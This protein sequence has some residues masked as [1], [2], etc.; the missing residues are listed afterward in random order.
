MT[1]ALLLETA[2]RAFAA[3]CTPAALRRAE[4]EGWA[5]DVWKAAAGIGL[6]WVGV[7]E[8]AG[9]AG[10]DLVDAVE[11]LRVAGAHAAPV[12][13]AE[14]GFLAGWLLAS[15][16]LPVG[17]EPL[18]VVPDGRGL[19]L[20]P[21]G[22]GGR[23][24]VSGRATG[25]A[26]AGRARAVVALV[27]ERVVVVPAASLH[28]EPSTNLAGEPRA[29]V[30]F[31]GAVPEADAAAPPGVTADA[32]RHRGALSRA[33]LMAGALEAVAL[34]TAAYTWERHQFG[35]PIATFQ[36]V[37]SMVVRA[38][39]EAV[40]ADLAVQAAARAALDGPATFEIGAAKLLAN[41][42][43]RTVTRAAH[44]AHG[45]I[46][47]TEEQ[48]LHHLTRRLWAWR[49]EYG[50]GAWPLALGRR[51][52]AAGAD[53]LYEVVAGGSAGLT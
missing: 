41:A 20:G 44:Q 17:D 34:R 9:G 25:V 36:L 52:A 1:E 24:E 26:W 8:A 39:E 32:L 3:T 49:A 53:R 42:A 23:G 13:L 15:A 43:A 31:D 45:A 6:P 28:I 27:E 16:G 10:G 48:G 40:L 4:A 11:V 50:D 5:P 51:V 46:G 7:P 33:A 21:G 47:M 30:V 29:T 35:K 38:T 37:Q 12:P 2:A 19:R 14:T 22:L 18:T